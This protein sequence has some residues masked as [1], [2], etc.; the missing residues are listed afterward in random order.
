[1]NNPGQI[2]MVENEMGEERVVEQPLLTVEERNAVLADFQKDLFARPNFKA[3]QVVEASRLGELVGVLP[4]GVK[5]V[6]MRCGQEV[7]REAEMR[8]GMKGQNTEIHFINDQKHLVKSY[9]D[10]KFLKVSKF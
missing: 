7:E 3:G 8:L 2:E 9:Y 10:S 4:G 1:M 6:V 5:G